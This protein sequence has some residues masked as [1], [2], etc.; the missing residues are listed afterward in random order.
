VII[1]KDI[2]TVQVR[3]TLSG[4]QNSIQIAVM[5]LWGW[6]VLPSAKTPNPARTGRLGLGAFFRL[7]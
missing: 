3:G 6:V 7:L 5:F 4:V 1:A 2:I